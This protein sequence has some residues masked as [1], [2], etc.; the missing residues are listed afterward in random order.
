MSFI[1][2]AL[3]LITLLATLEAKNELHT[4]SHFENEFKNMAR[5]YHLKETS[6]AFSIAMKILTSV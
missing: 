1:I 4:L 6:K 5:L 2:K 3:L